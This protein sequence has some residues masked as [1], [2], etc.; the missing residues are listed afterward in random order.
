MPNKAVIYA[1]VSSEGDRQNTDRQVVDL[2][3]YASLAGLEVVRVFTEKA[4][5]ARDDRPV[6]DECLD[7]CCA[8]NADILLLSE[9]SRLGR[10]VKII[11]DAVDRL[12][13][14]GVSIH[15][16]DIN[17]DTLLPT[18]EENGYATMLVTMLGLGAQM[19]RK[20]IMGRLNSGRKHAIENGVV[21]GRKRGSVKTREQKEAEYSDVIRLLKKGVS[22]RNV[23]KLCGKSPKTV[24]SI[25]NEFIK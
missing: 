8:G 2:K 16:Q 10:S 9:I 14:A 20:L 19:E 6:L 12:T 15:F 17:V 23:A 1:R 24:Q 13:K 3:A 18:G 11:V 21:M 5:G 22:I 25:K 7:W 4:S